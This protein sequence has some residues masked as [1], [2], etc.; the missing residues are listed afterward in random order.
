M[1][2]PVTDINCGFKAMKKEVLDEIA[3]YGN[4][5]RFLP[6]TANFR[7]FK[8]VELPVI[9]RPRKY[10]KSKF[11]PGKIFSGMFDTLRAYFIYQFS[12]KPLYFFGAI[13]GSLFL[14]GFFIG[15]YLSIERIFFGMLLYRRPALWLAV[16]LIIVGIQII[17]T[18]MIG[19]LIVY[20]NKKK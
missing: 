16:L 19:E 9:N 3:V 20:M 13:G 14:I 18:G 17:M 6:L 5:F 15:L 4:S 1:S 11:G 10:G 2:S 8:V 7:G 12:E